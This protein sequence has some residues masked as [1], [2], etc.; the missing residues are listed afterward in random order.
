MATEIKYLPKDIANPF[1]RNKELLP[2]Y[3]DIPEEFTKSFYCNNKW[4]KLF[5]DMFF[6]GIRIT[7]I[8]PKEGIDKDKAWRHIHIASSGWDSKHEHKEAGVSYLMS[9]WFEDVE[10]ETIKE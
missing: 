7:K 3:E 6:K 2:P 9:L 10:W 1:M 5:N 4:C 8:I